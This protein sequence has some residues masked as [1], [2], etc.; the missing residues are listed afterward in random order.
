MGRLRR[1]FCRTFSY[2]NFR[3]YVYFR[4]YITRIT[5]KKWSVDFSESRY[6]F[7]ALTDVHTVYGKVKVVSTRDVKPFIEKCRLKY[8]YG[9]RSRANMVTV[10]DSDYLL[11]Q[12]KAFIDRILREILH[13]KTY[14][15]SPFASSV[16]LG[17]QR[18]LLTQQRSTRCESF[19]TAAD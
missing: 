19:L 17:R 12:A 6:S 9:F 18:F 10:T 14:S 15:S 8:G 13:T 2:E 11:R 7:S 16:L 3:Y 1:S 4:E 5:Y